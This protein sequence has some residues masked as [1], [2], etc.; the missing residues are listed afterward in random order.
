MS[1]SQTVIGGPSDK[2]S[3]PLF[4]V[5]QHKRTIFFFT[6]ALAL[7]GVY[8]AY[9]V[10][11]SVF[12]ETN[13]PRVV[14]GIENGVMPVEQMQVTVTKPV[15]DAINSVPGLETVR[16]TTSR[17]SAEV[18]LFFNWDVDMADTLQLVDSAVSKVQQS[19]PA[20]VH[21]TTNRL[22]F[23]TFPILG[24]SLTSDTVTQTRLW[25]IATYDLRPPLNRLL[26]VSTV[27]VQGGKVPEVHVIPNPAALLASS[28]TVSDLLDAIRRANIIESPGLYEANHE[29]I[30]GLVGAQVHNADELAKVVVK[31]TTAGV[32]IRIGDV[33]EVKESTKPVYTI[34]TAE[35]KPAVLLNIARQ[36]SSNT[37]AVADE[38][39]REVEKL[40]KV[41]PPG[42]EFRPFYDQ[43]LL[44]RESISSVRDAIL[45]GLIL[46]SIILVVFLRDWSSSAVA[47]LVIPVTVMITIVFLKVT[48]QSFNLMTLGGLA[49]AVGL[50]IDD[51]I[52]VV[53]NIVLHRDAGEGRSEA[54][55]RALHEITVP[56][57]GSTI[58]PIVVF[59]PLISVTGVT[60]TFF[61]A[62]AIT[63]TVALLTSLLL[64]LTWTPSL[65]LVL[66]KRGKQVDA[67]VEAFEPTEPSDKEELRRL[68]TV[69]EHQSAF[70]RRILHWHAKSLAWAIARPVLLGIVCLFLVFGTWLAYRGLGSD[71]LPE[72]DEGGFILDYLS[73]AGTSLTETD[74]M[75]RHVERILRATP[76]VES[77]SRR[78]GL[79]M[80]LAA[81]TEANR[82]DFTI[83]LKTKRS[84]PIDEIMADVRTQV[85]AAEPALDVEF[86][87]V[88]QD[89]IGDLSNA[90]EPIQIKLSSE[91]ADLLNT[92]APRIAENIIKLPGVVDV[93]DGVDNTISG[94][95]TSFQVNTAVAA[96]LGF[97]PDEVSTDATALIEGAEAATPII[98]N[99]RPYTI[100]VRFDESHRS[101]LEAIQNTVMN[102]ATGH[103]STLGSLAE[104]KELP[105]QNE[106]FRENLVRTVVVTGRLEG[107]DLGSAIKRVRKSV[108][109]MHLPASVRVQYG[110]TYEEQQK[111]FSELLRVLVLALILV[112][113]VLLTEFRNFSAP[114]AI[115]ISSVLS[116]SGV[117]FALLITQSTFNVASFMGLIMVIGIVAKNGILLLDAEQK[118][119]SLDMGPREAMLEAAQRRL[120]PIVMTALATV[121]GMLPL[122]L[123]LGAGSQMLQPLAIA[124][125]GGVTVSMALSLIVTPAV[126]YFL[127]RN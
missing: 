126:Y 27:F 77:I 78:T 89:M 53:E 83:K 123:A 73:P 47:G 100:R 91:N 119:R 95:A 3:P 110:G 15:E 71:L 12:P 96:R 41:L 84:R 17:G 57:V 90:P 42:V 11:I 72:M 118:Y 43:S 63:M 125:I 52:V 31:S 88:L 58:T 20:T 102:S 13:F 82:G 124:V 122:A 61:R 65:S 99:G 37:V 24:Y 56:L 22:T 94:P 87:Q 49:A 76:E 66:L 81:V 39:A 2:P 93:L 127:T 85:R 54:V 26:G 34:V 10:P 21:I 38:V 113:G 33:A 79:Q 36:P 105:P 45:I 16:S 75:L 30:L 68:Q 19:L 46:A 9:K 116:T 106:I 115:L 50:V 101:S 70:M 108:E 1:S 62:L 4:W 67:A 98:Q 60:G 25:E 120:R 59:L 23:A 40:K 48:G 18:S 107:S 97:T 86:I 44:V 5:V 29:L 35:G 109:D 103:T 117:V 80:G 69:P 8:L 64:A 28:V 51:A 32:P 114:I 92:I 104:V 6:I 74:R 121:S 112:F 14:I 111:S 7:A 55:R